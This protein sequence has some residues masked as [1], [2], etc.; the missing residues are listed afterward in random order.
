MRFLN[1]STAFSSTELH[2]VAVLAVGLFG[3]SAYGQS[4]KVVAEA[5]PAGACPTTVTAKY[6]PGAALRLVNPGSPGEAR[7]P[8]QLSFGPA[9]EKDSERITQALVTVRG[10]S[11]KG[12]VIPARTT[13][14][15]SPW[16]ERTFSLNVGV[17]PAGLQS[18][19]LWL[20]GFGGVGDVRIDSITYANGRVWKA[21]AQ[22]SCHAHT[23]MVLAQAK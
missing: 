9:G 18:G 17:N 10:I 4:Q 2:R 13:A 6:V 20:T 5:V 14:A 23:G 1:L 7:K 11:E 15:A 8:L 22:Q 12:G 3:V 19:T 21:T 16:V